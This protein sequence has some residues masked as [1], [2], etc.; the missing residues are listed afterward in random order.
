MR[1]LPVVALSVTV[2]AVVAVVPET[3]PSARA[4]PTAVPLDGRTLV[5]RGVL[6]Y[7]EAAYAAAVATLEQARATARLSPEELAECRF[8]LA[9]SFVA[10]GSTNAARRELRAL[11]EANPGYDLP[12]YTSPKVVTLFREVREEVENRPRLRAL[13]PVARG[14][15]LAVRFEAARTGGTAY[16]SA[17]W[18]W[19]GERAYRELP[20]RHGDGSARD[21]LVA[22][23]PLREG[24]LRAGDPT[25][26]L[27]AE[28][29]APQGLAQ[30]ASPERPLEVGVP[31]AP[32]LRVERR[33]VARSWWLW[34]IVGAVAA[35]G[36]ATGLYFALRPTPPATTDATFSFGFR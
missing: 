20:L 2:M 7:R 8:Y 3:T 14:A 34:T 35:G 19:R 13:P 6:A 30:L 32:G 28:A 24:T 25:V 27:W 22:E 31:S 11:V 21:D 18:R 4:A 10:L 15:V 29:R 17:F 36:A 5:Q 23:L 1:T 26:E 33:S 9:A 12:Q 16:G